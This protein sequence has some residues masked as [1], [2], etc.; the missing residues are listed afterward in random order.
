MA[1]GQ[2]SNY[3][4]KPKTVFCS[5]CRI[6]RRDTEGIS[7]RNDTGEYFMGLC[8]EGHTDGHRKVFADKPRQCSDFIG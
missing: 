8:P 2:I 5:S 3:E 6:F 4:T 1:R 7:R